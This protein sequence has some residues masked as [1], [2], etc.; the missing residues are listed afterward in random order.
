MADNAVL[1]A[2]LYDIQ[3]QYDFTQ[4]TIDVSAPRCVIDVQNRTI[5][6]PKNIDSLGVQYDHRSKAVYFEI[7]RYIND[8]DLLTQTCVVQWINGD[9]EKGNMGFYPIILYDNSIAGKLTLVW[10]IHNEATQ[11]AGD[12]HFAL[13][14]YTL[15]DQRTFDWNFNTL[16]AKSTIKDTLDVQMDSTI[17]I[18]PSVLSVWN[19]RIAALE[20][21]ASNAVSQAQ[22]YMLESMAWAI[23]SDKFPERLID[24]SK[25]YSEVTQAIYNKTNDEFHERIYDEGKKI[26][27]KLW[28]LPDEETII[29]L[30]EEYTIGVP[31]AT[32]ERKGLVIV[33]DGTKIED[34]VLSIDTS[35]DESESLEDLVS[36]ESFKT[37]LTKLAKAVSE[38]IRLD[39]NAVLK[40]MISNLN[41]NDHNMIPTS[42]YVYKLAERIG[43]DIDLIGNE[44]LTDGVNKLPQL[45]DDVDDLISRVHE[46]DVVDFISF[47]EQCPLG[48]TIF[49]TSSNTTSL[50]TE[51]DVWIGAAG[52]LIKI[53]E[54]E[55][56]VVLFNKEYTQFATMSYIDGFWNTWTIGVC[57]SEIESINNSI[58]SIN[59]SIS[60][61]SINFDALET[62]MENFKNELSGDI[63]TINSA[64]EN[65]EQ[66]YKQ[67]D[68]SFNERTTTIE[69]NYV[70]LSDRVYNLEAYDKEVKTT[71]GTI[72]SSIDSINENLNNYSTTEYI[73]NQISSLETS[74]NN[75]IGEIN[76]SL[77][78]YATT[79]S[80]NQS[81]QNLSNSVNT[82][83]DNYSTTEQIN[84]QI[85]ELNNSII[86]NEKTVKGYARKLLPIT[87][88]LKRLSR[89]YE[90][91]DKSNYC[92][93]S[94]VLEDNIKIYLCRGDIIKSIRLNTI[95]DSKKLFE[96]AMIQEWGI[97]HESLYSNGTYS[98]KELIN[99][100]IDD[101]YYDSIDVLKS[102]SFKFKVLVLNY[103]TLMEEGAECFTTLII[104]SNGVKIIESIEDG[105]KL[106]KTFIEPSI[107]GRHTTIV[108]HG[109]YMH[110]FTVNGSEKTSLWVECIEDYDN[111]VIKTISIGEVI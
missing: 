94:E 100:C 70:N 3:Q 44:S 46:N 89:L 49:S 47:N 36:E 107:A 109:N 18:Q 91:V 20:R 14:F 27:D 10:E 39:Q 58:R 64:I 43:I 8:V 34:G 32:T 104:S 79:S 6:V 110:W 60:D 80:V 42:A 13:R 54:T 66:S 7:D 75:K 86:N 31:T 37:T 74:T 93:V 41:V 38:V 88:E 106:V 16:P 108:N 81:V 15:N 61:I 92:L 84:E 67:A 83:F 21:D 82:K 24:N 71:L 65:V 50:P 111:V 97:V 52:F 99:L 11:I 9:I 78:D 69:Q 5:N 72:D 77:K 45:R 1:L 103:K 40:S 101:V 35:F 12:I 96:V 25:Y 4:T 73:N 53:T 23:G 17:E 55:S 48:F 105:S 63:V 51:D 62:S 68:I 33:G 59:A 57:R 56:R 95:G 19:Y 22:Y 29:R 98:T 87:G 30:D 26:A 2:N 90:E 28:L 76:E 85:N 102:E